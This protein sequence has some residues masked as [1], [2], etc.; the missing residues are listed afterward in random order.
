MFFDDGSSVLFPADGICSLEELK[1]T[2][3][4][5][6]YYHIESYGE[7]EYSNDLLRI[8]ANSDKETEW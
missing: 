3:L 1:S 4:E 7:E 6:V 2:I 8:K 5:L